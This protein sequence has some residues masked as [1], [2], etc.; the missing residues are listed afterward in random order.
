MASNPNSPNPGRFARLGGWL[1]PILVLVV[2]AIMSSVFVVDARERA[3]VTRFGQ[4]VRVINEP[5]L[6]FKFPVIE[7]VQYYD[8]RILS[9]TTRPLEVTPLDDRRL[10]VDAFAR[11]RIT[12]TVEFREAVGPSGVQG[13]QDRI[14][15]IIVNAIR[16]VLGSV[17]S[18][19]VLSDDRTPLM[20]QIR[21][22][23]RAS[24]AALGVEVIDVRLTRTDLP[25]QNLEATFAR[26]RA[27]RE[28]EA[29]DERARG[30]EAAQRVRA[31]AD[32]TVVELTSE[33]RRNAEIIRGQADARRNAVF[34]E[35]YG[36]DPEFFAFVRSMQAYE[37][38]MK[39]ENSSMVI[40]PEGEF[41]SY[42]QG[43]GAENAQ[44]PAPPVPQPTPTTPDAAMPPEAPANGADTT[45]EGAVPDAPA[46]DT[47]PDAAPDA[48]GTSPAAGST[49]PDA[50][51]PPASGDA[52]TT[53]AAPDAAAPDAGA[54]DGAAPASPDAQP[55]A[56]T[57]PA[58]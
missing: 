7:Q 11:W 40:A 33:A 21:D 25:D 51:A 37:A 44:T 1:L 35:A 16:A 23:A 56:P 46:G 48:A 34:A 57:A 4:V 38:S 10:I 6:G 52:S 47:A 29:A 24:A 3:L 26:M 19:T 13:A 39:G 30:G 17:P 42:M 45:G 41:F 36:R 55:A 50:S 12:D 27:E 54:P 49:A 2:F 14:Q 53:P 20:N 8:K 31:A 5:G 58:N 22:Q 32:R 28:R 43:D 15:P 9:L 18:T